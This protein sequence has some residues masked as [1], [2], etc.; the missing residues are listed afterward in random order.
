MNDQLGVLLL[1]YG[2]AGRVFHA[3]LIKAAP[4]LQLLAVVT[5]NPERILQAR[6]DLPDARIHADTASA[7]A[8]SEDI[9]LVVVANANRAH[10]VDAG[11]AIAAGK[12]VVVDKP[13]AGSAAQAQQLGAQAQAAGVQLHTFQN[14]RWDSDFL[15][16]QSV[17][18]SGQL[19]TAHRLES[20]FERL[21][22][23]PKG[24][25][26]E[27]AA[28]Q[29]LGGVLLDFG[30][31]LVDQALALLGPV[32]CVDAYARSLRRPDGADDD[33]QLLL[34]HDSGALSLLFGS[35][36]SAFSGPRFS[37]LGTAGGFRIHDCDTQESRLR[38]GQLPGSPDW[39]AEAF[40]GELSLGLPDGGSANS[41]V[42][43]IAG[44]W[45]RF[46]EQVQAAI[47]TAAPWPVPLADVI[48]N[49]RV[50]DA[51]R[52]SVRTS[53]RVLLDPPATH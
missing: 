27:S 4:G 49:L 9:D 13:L 31:H 26:R 28:P 38:E 48:A 19:G 40:E 29:D 42:P 15:T 5:N 44:R 8:H 39:G 24:N 35:Q 32:V 53:A 1:G 12:H 34:T 52:E 45:T 51:A 20:R 22:V 41:G 37:L 18:A 7:L 46:Y 33:M 36:I 21:R 23:E 43:V 14:R 50:L 11:M 6:Q 17:L 2:L 10:V 16:L 3:P 47:A 25:W 30:A